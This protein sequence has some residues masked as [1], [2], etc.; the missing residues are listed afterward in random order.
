MNRRDDS[1]SFCDTSIG[2]AAK[3]RLLKESLLLIFFSECNLLCL[4][5][6][7]LVLFSAVSDLGRLIETPLKPLENFC[8]RMGVPFQTIA[9]YIYIG[10]YI[11]T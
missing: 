6:L 3:P 11:C 7:L 8:Y 1:L 2:F 4:F 10:I 5:W 9:L